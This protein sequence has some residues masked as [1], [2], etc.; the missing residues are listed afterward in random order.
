MPAVTGGITTGASAAVAMS[1]MLAAL[2]KV[3][4]DTAEASKISAEAKLRAGAAG[5]WADFDRAYRA[6]LPGEEDGKSA[7]ADA[8]SELALPIFGGR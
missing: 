8:D 7:I 6:G 1:P 5:M 4:H 2:L 3:V